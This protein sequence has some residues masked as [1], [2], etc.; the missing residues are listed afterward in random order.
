MEI[1]R[2]RS[3]NTHLDGFSLS[4]SQE[5]AHR[6]ITSLS[7]QM[8]Y[9]SPNKG[10]EEFSFPITL[11][12]GGVKKE[13]KEPLNY[14]T[15]SVE[16]TPPNLPFK[17]EKEVEEFIK[18]LNPKSPNFPI[19]IEKIPRRL[20]YSNPK[21]EK[22]VSKVMEKHYRHLISKVEKRRR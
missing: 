4:L 9:N 13:K 18:T 16:S 2:I 21:I 22:L 20:I 19:I 17:S 6:L 12:T 8:R 10:R 15:M 3:R 5:E 14:F 7:E 11:I 1:Y